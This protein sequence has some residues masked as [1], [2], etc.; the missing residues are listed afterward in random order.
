LCCLP[1]EAIPLG[2]CVAKY[3]VCCSNDD[4][5][6]TCTKDLPVCCPVDPEDVS[7]GSYCCADGEDCCVETGDCDEDHVCDSGCCVAEESL[8]I[9]RAGRGRADRRDRSQPRLRVAAR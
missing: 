9:Q 5:G 1:T 8:Q 3:D 6:G 7:E 4:G 2:A